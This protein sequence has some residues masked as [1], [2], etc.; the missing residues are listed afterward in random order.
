MSHWNY[1][2]LSTEDA[3]GNAAY[4]INEVYYDEHGRIQSWTN[5]P[6]SPFG[7]RWSELRAD[8]QHYLSAFRK[9][10]LKESIQNGSPVL[11]EV[12]EDQEVNRGHYPEVVDRIA[13]ALDHCAD[14]VGAHPVIRRHPELR[15]IYQKAEDA[16]AELYQTAANIS[17][18]ANGA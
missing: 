17:D 12:F 10:V 3:G 11:D 16:L 15:A 2:I 5:E 1:R 6:V 14:A 8:V 13:V 9:P 7:E 18:H 4:Q